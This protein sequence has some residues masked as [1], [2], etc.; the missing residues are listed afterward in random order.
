MGKKK[1]Q[2]VTDGSGNSVRARPPSRLAR[3]VARRR[4]HLAPPPAA[5]PSVAHQALTPSPLGW[6]RVAGGGFAPTPASPFCLA[7]RERLAHGPRGGRGKGG[8]RCPP[9][10]QSEGEPAALNRAHAQPRTFPGGPPVHA[11][12]RKRAATVGVHGGV[13]ENRCTGGST[14]AASPRLTRKK[15]KAP[16]ARVH[17]RAPV[18]PWRCPVPSPS[19]SHS[20]RRA[21]PV[22][23]RLPPK[24]RRTVQKRTGPPNCLPKS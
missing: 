5:Q 11:R 14:G 18:H 16:R 8:G 12:A 9:R 17:A 10:G 7:G 22:L 19:H 3:G 2:M 1:P 21:R 20:L 24:Q 15:R 13:S 4:L 23:H 6:W